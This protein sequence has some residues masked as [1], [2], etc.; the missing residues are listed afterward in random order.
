MD[1]RKAVIEKLE[2]FKRNYKPETVE[3]NLKKHLH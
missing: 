1:V 2:E 3:I